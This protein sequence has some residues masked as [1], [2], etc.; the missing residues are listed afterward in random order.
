MDGEPLTETINMILSQTRWMIWKSRCINRY[1]IPD[2]KHRNLSNFVMTGLKNH[3]RML[4]MVPKGK[5]FEVIK[6]L[7][8]AFEF[9]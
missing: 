9:D 8:N 1:E 3:L 4:L 5:Y 2:D 7:N 6:K